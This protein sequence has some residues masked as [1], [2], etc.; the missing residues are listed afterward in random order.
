[1]DGWSWYPRTTSSAERIYSEVQYISTDE[2]N[3]LDF[4]L[5]VRYEPFE[6]PTDSSSSFSRRLAGGRALV[7][8]NA[9]YR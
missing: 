6:R 8:K 1:M 9:T 2:Q 3:Y 5:R 7:R 4:D